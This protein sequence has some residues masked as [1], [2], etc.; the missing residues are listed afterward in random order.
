MVLDEAVA[1]PGRD[2]LWLGRV[3]RWVGLRSTR[4]LQR[5]QNKIQ[6]NSWKEVECFR[7]YSVTEVECFKFYSLAVVLI[8]KT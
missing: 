2:T 5:H 7:F 6:I 1:L 3:G 8:W 4:A